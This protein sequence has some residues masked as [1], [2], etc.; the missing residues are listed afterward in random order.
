MPFLDKF[1]SIIIARINRLFHHLLF[2]AMV[3]N[4]SN[5][6]TELYLDFFPLHKKYVHEWAHA[7][8]YRR[9]NVF[10]KL[11]KQCGHLFFRKNR[12]NILYLQVIPHFSA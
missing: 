8:P 6:R 10:Q 1:F 7:H 5:S 12:Y 3:I 4:N 2:N 11:Y 9:K